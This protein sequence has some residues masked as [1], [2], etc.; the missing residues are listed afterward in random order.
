[1]IF[2]RVTNNINIKTTDGSLVKYLRFKAPASLPNETVYISTYDDFCDLN[3]VFERIDKSKYFTKILNE[4]NVR[5]NKGFPIELGISTRNEFDR[6]RNKRAEEFIDLSPVDLYR[7]VKYIN[8][9]NIKIAIIGG[10]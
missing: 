1:M 3:G 7:Q 6:D 8:K 5:S 9:D 10:M 2:F 4:D